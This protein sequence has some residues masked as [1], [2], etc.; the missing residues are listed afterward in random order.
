MRKS[1][2]TILRDVIIVF[3]LNAVYALGISLFVTPVSLAIGGTTG[4]ALFI[5]HYTNLS[6]SVFILIFNVIMF[7]W[8]WAMFGR[9]FALTTIVS[10]FA[11]PISLGVFEHLLKGVVLTENL[12][13]CV[14]FG[15]LFVGEIIPAYNSLSTLTAS[16][17]IILLVLCV[18][19]AVILIPSL[20]AFT[21]F[22]IKSRCSS[23]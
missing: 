6:L 5:Q 21:K 10:T 20:I 17:V 11:Y 23:E 12:M 2:L 9:K 13:L 19:G 18:A 1:K 16:N 22:A 8:G 4:L 7:F 3:F 14:I 15:G